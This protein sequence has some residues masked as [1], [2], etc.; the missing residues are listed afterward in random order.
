MCVCVCVCLAFYIKHAK[1]M[2][3]IKLTYVACLAV[4]YFS[5]LSK[6]F[7]IFLNRLLKTECVLI[8]FTTFVLNI[9]HS[10]SNSARYNHKYVEVFME[11]TRY[12][13]QILM[14]LEFS[15][16]IFEKCLISWKCVHWGP[17]SSMR[18]VRYNEANSHS[19]LSCD[20]PKNWKALL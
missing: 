20:A 6:K 17:C 4:P 11:S 1:R 7:T 5:T 2:R 12:S 14:K 19:S 15:R 10:K 9:S 18:T 16:Q 3:L 13:C 8:L